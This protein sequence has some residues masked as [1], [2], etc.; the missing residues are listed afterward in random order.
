MKP[1]IILDGPPPIKMDHL[2]PTHDCKWSPLGYAQQVPTFIYHKPMYPYYPNWDVTWTLG[3]IKLRTDGR[4]SWWRQLS[5]YWPVWRAGEGVA[6]TKIGAIF[7][8]QEGWIPQDQLKLLP[9]VSPTPMAHV[10]KY[11]TDVVLGRV[12]DTHTGVWTWVRHKSKLYPEWVPGCGTCGSRRLA[13]QNLMDGWPEQFQP[14]E[15]L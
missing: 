7:S 14:G 15:K 8:V 6:L 13:H 11:S 10:Y 9:T 1:F 2:L 5:Q 4:W 12:I 3:T